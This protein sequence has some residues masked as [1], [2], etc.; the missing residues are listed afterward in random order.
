M[1]GTLFAVVGPSG[2]GKDTLIDYARQHLQDHSRFI[3]PKRC[4]TRPAG[5]GGED[6]V[7]VTKDQFEQMK[8]AGAF[9]LDWEAHG[10]HYGIPARTGY[11]L[12]DG[13]NVVIN[14]SRAAI[15][16]LSK[17]VERVVVVY[18]DAPKEVV[19]ERLEARGREAPGDIEERLARADASLPDCAPV[20]TLSNSGTVKEAGDRLVEIL[21]SPYP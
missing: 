11:M 3:F 17:M 19:A 12:Q 13:H 15:E 6:H 18:V 2:A 5:A 9:F 16:P 8:D 7:S 20:V 21:T 4:I 14:M 1:S 10:L